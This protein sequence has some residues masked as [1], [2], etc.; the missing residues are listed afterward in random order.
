MSSSEQ[1]TTSSP[2]L[3]DARHE[4][5]SSPLPPRAGLLIIG[6]GIAGMS[7][8]ASLAASEPLLLESRF[9]GWGASGRNAGFILA[10]GPHMDATDEEARIRHV[11]LRD[12]GLA[13]RAR[14]HDLSATY[15][16]S[17][18]PTGSVRLADNHAEAEA[19]REAP[20]ARGVSVVPASALPPPWDTGRWPAGRVDA[21]DAVVD[22]VALIG[23]LRA[24]AEA[25]GARVRAATHVVALSADQDGVRVT[26][27]A[28]D[29]VAQ[30]VL[31]AT[32][33][34]T[35][36]LVP[37]I[38]IRPRRAQMLEALVDGDVSWTQPVYARGGADYWRAMPD[39]RVLVGGCRDAGGRDEE[40]DAAEPGALVQAALDRLLHEL[41][42]ER[43]YRVT[44]RWAG[45]MGFTPDGAPWIGPLPSTDRVWLFAG[46]HGHGMGWAPGLA[47]TV[48]TAVRDGA[49]H[50]P[51]VFRITGRVGLP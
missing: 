18:R 14:L 51:P 6:G 13:T 31:V 41:L 49:D 44:R 2:W 38:P 29:V 22:P 33:A 37:E 47:Q 50:I 1:R 30:H 5:P 9:P 46:F 34:W 20:H 25:G 28:G 40:T 36:Q 16:F 8:A 43:T 48:A 11:A 39:G 32:N 23:A 45:I 27:D 4:S 10:E 21:G 15:E 3:A 35:R 26:T 12:A 7:L 19:F 24:E 17:L 42:P